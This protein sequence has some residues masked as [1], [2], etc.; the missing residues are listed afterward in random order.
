VTPCQCEYSY[1]RNPKVLD[2]LNHCEKHGIPL[3]LLVGGDEVAAGLVKVKVVNNREDK[4]T[5]VARD[6]L[7]ADL[8]RRLEDPA[9]RKLTDAADLTAM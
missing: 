7:V 9:V 1:K 6:A 5:P 4:G 2:Q 8:R 3:A